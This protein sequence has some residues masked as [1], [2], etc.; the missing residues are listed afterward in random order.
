[1]YKYLKKE[2]HT[3]LNYFVVKQLTKYLHIQISVD[4]WY[5]FINHW[6]NF[7]IPKF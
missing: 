2:E 5:Y 4:F 3:L 7:K 1:M 6:L